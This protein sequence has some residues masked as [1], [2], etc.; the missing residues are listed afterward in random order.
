MVRSDD[1]GL[2]VERTT[3]AWIRTS[4]AFAVVSLLLIR[5]GRPETIVVAM[6]LTLTGLAA[7]IGLSLVQRARHRGRVTDF[8]HSDPVHGFRAVGVATGLTLLLVLAALW[9]VWL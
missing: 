5:T 6:V 1:P 8:N 3:L 9:C 7:S 4:M 2:Q